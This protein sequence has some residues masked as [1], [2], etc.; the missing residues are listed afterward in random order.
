[1]R[2]PARTQQPEPPAGGIPARPLSDLDSLAG[3]ERELVEPRVERRELLDR[4]ARLLRDRPE[5]VAVLHHVDLLRQPVRAGRAPPCPVAR[6]RVGAEV[7]RL[8]GLVRARAAAAVVLVR[9]R[10]DQGEADAERDQ[11]DG[12]EYAQRAASVAR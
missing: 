5:R 3:P 10:D 12:S 7:A 8:L 11:R 9:A 4:N 1:M 6:G 2:E